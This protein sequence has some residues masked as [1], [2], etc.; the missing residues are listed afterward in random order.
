MALFR[1]PDFTSR[2]W[3]LYY[4]DAYV[5]QLKKDGT[6]KVLV[7]QHANDKFIVCWDPEEAEEHR[8][9]TSIKNLYDDW[10]LGGYINGKEGA[11]F[12]TLNQMKAY[13]R[14]LIPGRVIHEP[15]NNTFNVVNPVFKIQD[16][17]NPHYFTLKQAVKLIEDEKMYSVALDHR[18][19]ITLHQNFEELYLMY[20]RKY[21]VGKVNGNGI[22]LHPSAGSLIEQLSEITDVKLMELDDAV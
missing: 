18:F 17:Y 19:A 7:V 21:Y 2:D 10:P 11:I 6:K 9:K 4:T 15:L 13:Q 5:Y 3:A 8:F 20:N 16:L 22:D 14:P 1:N 12:V